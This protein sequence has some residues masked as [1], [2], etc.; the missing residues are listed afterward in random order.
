M[1]IPQKFLRG[2]AKDISLNWKPSN[3]QADVSGILERILFE[4][5]IWKA[6]V[7][8]LKIF[9]SVWLFCNGFVKEI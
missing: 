9:Y 2:I 4:I 6:E 8:T 7:Y 3:F 5:P 1:G